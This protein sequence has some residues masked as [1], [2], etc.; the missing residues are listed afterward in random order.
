MHACRL[1]PA[2]FGA[3]LADDERDDTPAVSAAIKA[4]T[5]N[6]TL[7]FPAGTYNVKWVA[8]V[9]DFIWYNCWAGEDRLNQTVIRGNRLY[10]NGTTKPLVMI[11]R[12]NQSVGLVVEDNTVHPYTPPPRAKAR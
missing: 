2:D 3:S 12:D 10:T 9:S 8:E 5:N 1:F 6:S 11:Q 4:A 7:Y